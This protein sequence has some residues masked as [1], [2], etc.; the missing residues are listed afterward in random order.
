MDV[1]LLNSYNFRTEDIK[2]SGISAKSM[3]KW[4]ESSRCQKIVFVLDCCYAELFTE[5]MY[6]A[7]AER[8]CTKDLYLLASS[9]VNEPTVSD[10]SWL[11]H[12]YMTFFIK[13]FFN[14]IW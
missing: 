14:F 8:E 7:R 10:E 9:E 6:R 5:A 12:G 1:S 3:F 11:E 2:G 13:H 4:M